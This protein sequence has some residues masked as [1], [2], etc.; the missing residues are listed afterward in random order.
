MSNLWRKK[1]EI[2]YCKFIHLKQIY[3]QNDGYLGKGTDFR[4]EKAT[5]RVI[6]LYHNAL[7]ILFLYL[8]PSQGKHI[9]P[10]KFFRMLE[11]LVCL[12]TYPNKRQ[13][14]VKFVLP[15]CVRF[16]LLDVYFS[17]LIWLIL[18]LLIY[19]ICLR[20]VVLNM[21]SFFCCSSKALL[22]SLLNTICVCGMFW[23]YL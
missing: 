17:M 9:F 21:S 22:L 23:K 7:S 15:F 3:L 14:M 16:S 13:G 11:L 10:W 2:I 12:F 5:S 18:Y 1:I 20:M 6:Y 4:H 19:E 8:S